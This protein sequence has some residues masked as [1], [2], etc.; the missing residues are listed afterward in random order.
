MAAKE[1]RWASHLL[2]LCQADL[3][4]R[5]SGQVTASDASL[6][7]MAVCK[8]P[9]DVEVQSQLGGYKEH[10][11]FKSKIPVNPRTSALQS[12]DPFLHPDTL[13]PT[14]VEKVDAFELDEEFPNVPAEHFQSD[15]WHEV[16]SVRMMLPEHITLLEGRGVVASLRHKVRS[17]DEF[18]RRHLHFS[19]NLA[20]AL[21]AGKGRSNN[22]AMLRISRRI[23]AF[24]LATNCSF[25]VRWMP[26][27]LNVADKGSRQWEHLREHH[28]TSRSQKERWKKEANDI[29]YGQPSRALGRAVL[30]MRGSSHSK[31][32]SQGQLQSEDQGGEAAVPATSAGSAGGSSTFPGADTPGEGGC[33][34]SGGNHVP[35]A[36]RGAEVFCEVTQTELEDKSQ[37]RCHLL[38]VCEQH[39]RARVRRARRQQN[40]GSHRRCLS[41]LRPEAHAAAHKESLARMGKIGASANQT[42]NSMAPAGIDG[43]DHAEK[44]AEGDSRGSASDVHWLSTARRSAGSSAPRPGSSYNARIKTLCPSS[45]S[46]AKTT[47]IKSGAKRRVHPARQP[48]LALAGRCSDE[49]NDSPGV[50]FGPDLQ[51]TGQGME[52]DSHCLGPIRKTCSA[53]PTSACRSKLRPASE[54][55]DFARGEA[56]RQVGCRQQC[57]TLRST[58]ANQPRVPPFAKEPARQ[59]LESGLQLPK[60]GPKVF[61]PVALNDALKKDI[62]IELFS[63][64]ARLSSAC[65]SVG[66]LSLAYDI[67]YNS[68]CDLCNL[69]I[70]QSVLSFIQKHSHRIALVWMGT[71]CSSWSRARKHDGG[72]KP[73]RDDRQN[74]LGFLDVSPQDRNNIFLGNSLMATSARIARHCSLLH[75]SY[76]IENPFSSRI[77]LT[78][79]FCKLRSAG[80]EFGRADFLRL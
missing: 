11:R 78:S 22:F 30:E 14:K 34:P 23:A 7:G 39:V 59:M 75:I 52:A 77:W 46:S 80:A 44:E 66:F 67:E 10:W 65:S 54:P 61:W 28:A 47:A 2:Q 15:L 5:W 79:E 64:C 4:K 26:S 38:Q 43:A 1:A 48:P 32:E 56:A 41:R 60:R 49:H 63:G 12:M 24:L 45:A 71:P 35:K 40:S 18:H 17:C 50:S 29:C 72:P 74:L 69:K 36:H 21:L 68:W 73:L 37:L 51:Q 13:K 16:F 33:V 53:V 3:T 57:E 31:A 76:V 27:E 19:D 9:M 6:S 55:S 42:S 62:V 8:R 70:L 20:V 58:R 25:V